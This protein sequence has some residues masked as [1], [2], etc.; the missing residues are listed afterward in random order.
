MKARCCPS[1]LAKHYQD[2]LK[3]LKRS[4]VAPNLCVPLRFTSAVAHHPL[5]SQIRTAFSRRQSRRIRVLLPTPR[6]NRTLGRSEGVRI[7][8]SLPRFLIVRSHIL[9]V[10]IT[11]ITREIIQQWQIRTYQSKSNLP[12]TSSSSVAQTSDH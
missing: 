9:R 6:N 8:V 1:R 10:K 11:R 2:T 3:A 5:K 12:R 4:I 7:H